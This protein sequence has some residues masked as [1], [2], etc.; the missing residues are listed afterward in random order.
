MCDPAQNIDINNFFEFSE[1][2]KK[3][4]FAEIVARGV[5]PGAFSGTRICQNVV[6]DHSGH[7]SLGST[8]SQAGLLCNC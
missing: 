4:H 2:F 7:M 5:W 6:G 8:V 1:K 3:F